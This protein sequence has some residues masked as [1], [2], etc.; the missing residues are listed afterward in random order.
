MP[1]K[2]ERLIDWL[3]SKATGMEIVSQP[4]GLSEDEARAANCCANIRYQCLVNFLATDQERCCTYGLGRYDVT[5]AVE[6]I[7]SVFGNTEGHAFAGGIYVCGERDPIFWDRL[8][9]TA[10]PLAHTCVESDFDGVVDKR[11]KRPPAIRPETANAVRAFCR[12][13]PGE[14]FESRMVFTVDG[15]D[16][17]L[18]VFWIVSHGSY[19]IRT[20]DRTGNAIALA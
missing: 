7:W 13:Y 17:L 1:R 6:R 11:R 9:K 15:V 10:Y 18:W 19:V 14:T 8:V 16:W 12:D 3:E 5:P 2:L 20:T 4:Q